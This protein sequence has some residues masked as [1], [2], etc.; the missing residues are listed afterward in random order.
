MKLVYPSLGGHW[1]RVKNT[2]LEEALDG[3][4]RQV[5]QAAILSRFGGRLDQQ[6]AEVPQLLPANLTVSREQLGSLTQLGEG[7]FSKVYSVDQFSLPGTSTRLAFKEFTTEHAAQARATHAAVAFRAE[8]G[9]TERAEL[10]RGTVWPR[11]LVKNISGAISGYLMPLLSQEFFCR[12]VGEETG[13]LAWK[14]RHMSWLIARPETIQAAEIDLPNISFSERLVLLSQ[15]AENIAFLHRHGWVF[16]DL[17]F[18]NAVFALDPLRMILLDCDGA[19]ALDDP[20]RRQY[21]TPFWEAPELR[22]SPSQLQDNATDIYKLGLAI[23]RCLTPGRGASSARSVARLNGRLGA[24]GTD[25]ISR[26]L[27]EDP[28]VRPTAGE[29]HAYLRSM[30]S[31]SREPGHTTPEYRSS[32]QP[33]SYI[34]N[35][36]GFAVSEAPVTLEQDTVTSGHVFIS[37]DR[38]DSS[39]IDRL[40][41]AFMSAGVRVWRDTN[42]IWPGEDWQTKIRYAITNDALVFLACFSRRSLERKA[43]YRNEEVALAI[44]QL[45]LRMPGE[46]WLI[47]VRL[48]DCGIPD[49]DIGGGRTLA[50]IQRADLFGENLDEKIG[51][52]I[53]AVQRILEKLGPR[54]HESL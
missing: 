27:S 12:L 14:P 5:M 2:S 20:A 32:G 13:Q 47:P 19:A 41:Q 3:I 38:V 44:S 28:A 40:H 9:F 37:Y 52:L 17:S 15:L 24:E 21:S 25:L 49:L 39:E 30:A 42:E 54:T 10:D 50:S 6:P 34:S 36:V 35:S 48:D 45:R 43:S 26:T 16:G 8:L 33:G 29:L 46:P 31:A 7:G 11:A 51:R 4:L 18:N 22:P 53:T 1:N 23:L